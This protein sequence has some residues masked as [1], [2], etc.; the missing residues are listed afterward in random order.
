MNGGSPLVAV[1]VF[2][3]AVLGPLLLLSPAP[4]DPPVPAPPPVRGNSVLT[5]RADRFGQFWTAG[6]VNGVPCRF[7]V[8][9]GASDIA[10]G[11]GD[12]RRLGIDPARL[13]FNET[14][15]TANGHIRSAMVRVAWLQVGPF[16]LRDVP[17]S[18]DDSEMD[19]PLLGMS[20]LRRFR[21][22]IRDDA[23]TIS[24]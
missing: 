10:F 19:A 17:V 2:G 23:I 20:F 7:L 15:W 24:D 4:V 12:A 18:I 3:A 22:A 14:K 5:L 1:A 13:V 8:D 9:T 6:R 11:R 21:L 16:L